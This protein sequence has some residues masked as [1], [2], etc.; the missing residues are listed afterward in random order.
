MDVNLLYVNQTF[1]H[2]TN[3]LPIRAIFSGIWVELTDLSQEEMFYSRET[4]M[5]NKI[6]I[7]MP[8]KSFFSQEYTRVMLEGDFKPTLIISDCQKNC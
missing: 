4:N 7:Q 1:K 5:E 6:Y 3:A 2:I 8:F